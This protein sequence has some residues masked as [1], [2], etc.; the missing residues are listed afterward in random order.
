MN[1]NC[2]VFFE[3]KKPNLIKHLTLHKSTNSGNGS[4]DQMRKEVRQ[5]FYQ[6][7]KEPK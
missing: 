5:A 1:S 7:G 2:I 4:N 6:T 3:Y